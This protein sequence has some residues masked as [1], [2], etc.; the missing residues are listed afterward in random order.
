MAKLVT[1]PK[2]IILSNAI[3]RVFWCH[4]VRDGKRWT[5]P[6]L[7]DW[8]LHRAAQNAGVIHG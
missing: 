3:R 8:L 1:H 7:L 6:W 5:G 2:P 4:Q